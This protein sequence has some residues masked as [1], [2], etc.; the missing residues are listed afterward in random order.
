M[1]DEPSLDEEHIAQTRIPDD[2]IGALIGTDGKSK[3][4]LQEQSGCDLSIDSDTGE[5]EIRSD[6]S[7]DVYFMQEVVNAVGNGFNPSTA[8]LILKK[9][10]LFET[11]NIKDY[12]A[13]DQV[14]RM[15]GRVIGTNGKTRETIEDLTETHVS[16]YGHTVNVIGRT[17]HIQAARRAVEKLLNGQSHSSVYKALEQHRDQ[18]QRERLMNTG[19]F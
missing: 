14:T 4:R 9:D 13:D 1:S 12:V 11:L 3:K 8:S 16:V 10:Y 19:K 6:S 15:K 7:V 17:E 18:V 5:V 2:R